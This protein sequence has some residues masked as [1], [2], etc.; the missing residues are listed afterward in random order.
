MLSY[1]D[2]IVPVICY[3][4][5]TLADGIICCKDSDGNVVVLS[6]RASHGD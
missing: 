2:D 1:I 6:I 5:V 3:P 4:H